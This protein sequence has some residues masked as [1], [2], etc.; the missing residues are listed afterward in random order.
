MHLRRQGCDRG[1][2]GS[3]LCFFG[4]LDG[5]GCWFEIWAQG[6]LRMRRL[7]LMLARLKWCENGFGY[8]AG[9]WCQRRRWWSVGTLESYSMVS[10]YCSIPELQRK[11]EYRGGLQNGRRFYVHWNET[12]EGNL[13]IKLAEL[14]TEEHTIATMTMSTYTLGGR[15]E[16]DSLRVLHTLQREVLWQ[17]DPVWVYTEP[18]RLPKKGQPEQFKILDLTFEM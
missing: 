9:C 4:L 10:L 11:M 18:S 17:K 7:D 1:W 16:K 8:E 2:P 6:F 14:G 12:F 5:W 13:N 3:W 15:G